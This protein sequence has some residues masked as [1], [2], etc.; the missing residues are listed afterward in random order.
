MLLRSQLRY[1]QF[2]KRLYSTSQRF[3]PVPVADRLDDASKFDPD[4]PI[5]LRKGFSNLPAI[6]KWF[7][8]INDDAAYH[9][10]DSL[11]SPYLRRYEST[12]VPLEL[13][14]PQSFERFEAPLALLLAHMPSSDYL[15]FRLYLAQCPLSDLPPEMQ[16]DLPTPDIVREIGKGDIYGSSLWMGKPPT[17]TPLHRDPNPN[18]F[19]QLAGK[20]VVRLMDPD[21][22]R[23][24][25]ESTRAGAGHANMRGEEM[26]VGEEA[27]RLENAV[28]G[29]NEDSD[30]TAS[31]WEAHLESGQA[32]YVPLGYW[33]AVRGVGRGV[34]ASN[35]PN[36]SAT[37]IFWSDKDPPY[38]D[39][40][41][42]RSLCLPRW[43]QLPHRG[44]LLPPHPAKARASV[45]DNS[46]ST[47]EG[48]ILFHSL[49][50][51]LSAPTK[52][53]TARWT[54]SS[55]A[56]TSS[57]ERSCM[58]EQWS[59]PAGWSY[60]LPSYFLGTELWQSHVFCTQCADA[61]GLSRAPNANRQCPAC[62]TRLV[63]PDDVVVACLNP[64]E[65]YKT[66]VLSGLSPTIIM[67]CASRGLQFYSYQASQ[68]IVYQEHLAKSLTEKY[69]NLSQQM[70]QLIHDANAHIKALQDKVQSKI[71]LHVPNQLRVIRAGNNLTPWPAMH[72][73]QATLEQKNHDL[74]DAFREKS[75]TQ[76]Q[77]QK[78]YQSLKAQ[79]MSSHVAN[80]AGEEADFALQTVRNDRFV[81]RLPGTRT[82][83]ANM[84]QMGLG[85]TQRRSGNRHSRDDSGSSGNGGQQRGGAPL[86]PAWNAQPQGAGMS[87]RI[88]TG[89]SAPVGTPSQAQHRSRLPVLGGHRTNAFINA[90]GGPA[91]QPSPMTRQPLGAGTR[92]NL[93]GFGMGAKTSKRSGGAGVGG[94][95]GR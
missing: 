53:W 9:Q 44:M 29:D 16:A 5:V 71:V 27:E 8:L 49:L 18:L 72:A 77:L 79:V 93:G 69:S 57:A 51:H 65:D 47:P 55:D 43:S 39:S 85:M 24:L 83:T 78:L 35:I 37:T 10:F 92:N 60:I 26:M 11:D 64:S 46:S 91:Y 2:S 63:N 21:I 50:E 19:V 82:G 74:G 84:S 33:H 80:A 20:K 76:Q 38:G 70:D 88:Y 48:S 25:Y 89:N 13:A 36:A 61:T 7:K 12:T 67:E 14:R 87:S 40:L 34:N 66:S 3:I 31:G 68:E 54:S 32:L 23:T 41:R 94:P 15:D 58:I 95:L 86:G 22:G 17:R 59:L 90:E 75:R 73:E 28:W 30:T 56:M 4:K 45:V 52:S 81:D 42:F 62:G 6:W 1:C